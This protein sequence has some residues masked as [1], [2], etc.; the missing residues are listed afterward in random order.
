VGE[1]G[2]ASGE[3]VTGPPQARIHTV[4]PLETS[5]FG[6][7]GPVASTAL[8]ASGS[9]WATAQSIPSVTGRLRSPVA[10]RASHA[11]PLRRAPEGV[12]GS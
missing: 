8:P 4:S 2:R 1:D 3:P 5:P 9:A 7:M 12:R 10:E 11:L 6:W